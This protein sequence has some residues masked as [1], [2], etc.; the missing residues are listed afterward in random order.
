[1]P[2]RSL[3]LSGSFSGS[4]GGP[5]GDKENAG[6]EARAA[7]REKLSLEIAHHIKGA[8]P[9]CGRGKQHQQQQHS[10]ASA[11]PSTTTTGLSPSLPSIFFASADPPCAGPHGS[12]AT[13]G[14]GAGAGSDGPAHVLPLSP[15]STT[16]RSINARHGLYTF[17][18]GTGFG[19]GGSGEI[20]HSRTNAARRIPVRAVRAKTGGGSAVAF[21][22]AHVRAAMLRV[23]P[24]RPNSGGGRKMPQG[25]P[26]MGVQESGG[27]SALG[28]DEVRGRSVWCLF[29]FLM[30]LSWC[31]ECACGLECGG[32]AKVL[33]CVLPFCCRR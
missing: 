27:S 28:A 16:V 30:F 18:R 17:D 20:S 9:P 1:M 10:T 12:N 33:A 25:G 3:P 19:G 8:T 31:S 13:A 26:W 11:P 6:A 22:H 32:G 2:A 23:P 15:S 4:F 24:T 29:L 14:A 7:A 5:F 21:T